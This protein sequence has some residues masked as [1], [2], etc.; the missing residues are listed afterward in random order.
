MCTAC[1]NATIVLVGNEYARGHETRI[2]NAFLTHDET[3]RQC[4][5]SGVPSQI[6]YP[7]TLSSFLLSLLPFRL[8]RYDFV[9]GRRLLHTYNLINCAFIDETIA[10]THNTISLFECVS[11]K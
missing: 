9:I 1:M 7:M 3:E 5:C 8:L 4:M 6:I 2:C 10:T 11:P